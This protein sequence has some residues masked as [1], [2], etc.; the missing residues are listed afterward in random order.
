MHNR[1]LVLIVHCN[2]IWVHDTGCSHSAMQYGRIT[3]DAIAQCVHN[4]GG[5]GA[6]NY[7]MHITSDECNA[8]T[9]QDWCSSAEQS[10]ICAHNKWRIAV[11]LFTNS[12]SSWGEGSCLV[13]TVKD[14]NSLSPNFFKVAPTWVAWS[15]NNHIVQV[16]EDDEI[17]LPFS[18]KVYLGIIK[19]HWNGKCAQQ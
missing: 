17:K 7:N 15:E 4:T 14:W 8:P 12:I 9:T 2:A 18:K 5:S 19:P 16:N 13:Q 6:M 1:E 11:S 10:T 3:R